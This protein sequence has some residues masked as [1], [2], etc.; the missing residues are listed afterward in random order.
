MCEIRKLLLNTSDSGTVQIRSAM[1]LDEFDSHN[2]HLFLITECQVTHHQGCCDK[3]TEQGLP[4]AP[5]IKQTLQQ[6]E[7]QANY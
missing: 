4:V 2:C 6:C 7:K 1:Y 5:A 3:S